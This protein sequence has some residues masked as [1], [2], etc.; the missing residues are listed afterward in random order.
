MQKIIKD[1]KAFHSQNN[2]LNQIVLMIP[3]FIT[4]A[5][6]RVDKGLSAKAMRNCFFYAITSYAEFRNSG[7]PDDGN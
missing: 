3:L 5:S 2:K 6:I 7:I 4:I 1:R